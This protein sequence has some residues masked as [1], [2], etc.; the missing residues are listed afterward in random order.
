MNTA[1]MQAVVEE[2]N[3]VAQ[4]AGVKI[5][6]TVNEFLEQAVNE[7]YARASEMFEGLLE[8][9]NSGKWNQ[10]SI[11]TLVEFIDNFK[12]IN[13]VNCEQLEAYLNKTKASLTHYKAT[14][15]KTNEKLTSQMKDWLA[16]CS[17]RI[18]EMAETEKT[19]AIAN[20][21]NLGTRKIDP[22]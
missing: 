22:F 7:L 21:V 20:F 19:Q 10:K 4:E 17:K 15:I 6:N 11:N 2:R 18:S 9:V 16:R 1:E 8:N 14:D 12:Q 13:F 3:K 5:S